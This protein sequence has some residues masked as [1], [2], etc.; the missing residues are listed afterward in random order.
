VNVERSHNEISAADDFANFTSDMA[1]V[2]RCRAAGSPAPTN[3]GD[4][5]TPVAGDA[6]VG[7]IYDYVSQLLCR[8]EFI[9]RFE[10]GR[11]WLE[12]AACG[13]ESAGINVRRRGA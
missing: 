3:Q 10:P 5:G 11:V 4:A 6:G 9:R 7:R 13:H 2:C 12:C 1:S 8:H